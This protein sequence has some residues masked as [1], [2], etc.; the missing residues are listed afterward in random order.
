MI[1][2]PILSIR[3]G[4]R[5]I[6]ALT[7]LLALPLCGQTFDFEDGIADWQRSGNA[8]DKQPYCGPYT[9]EKFAPAELEKLGGSYWRTL[10]YPL[11]QHKSCLITTRGQQSDT[12]VG[13]LTSPEFYL[14]SETP[15][16][17]FRIG[18][19]EDI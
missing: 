16:L 15:F 18:G 17:S 3:Y 11:G 9:V 14:N 8:F 13:S 6:A 4:R 10:D 7:I 5:A 19:T 1:L 12:Q 2:N